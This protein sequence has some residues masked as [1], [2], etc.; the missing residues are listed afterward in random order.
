MKTPRERLALITSGTSNKKTTS[1]RTPLPLT[2][3]KGSFLA[4][5][6]SV[7][8]M[9]MYIRYFFF[10]IA[11]FITVGLYS[12]DVEPTEDPVNEVEN[13]VFADDAVKT[14]CVAN[15]DGDGDGELSMDEAAAVTELGSVFRENK[16]IVSFEELQYFTGL[17][18]IDNYAFYKSSI[19]IVVF[20]ET[21]TEI[22]EYAFSASN[23]RGELHVPGTVKEIHNYAFYSCRQLTAIILEE[24]V[25]TVGWHSFSGPIHTLLLPTTLSFMKSMAVDPYVNADPSSGLFLPDGDLWVFSYAET[26][27][28]I[29]EFAYYY[30]FG[31]C[32]LVV[33]YGTIDVYKAEKG[34]S[35][36]SSYYEIGDVNANGKIDYHDVEFLR[37]YLDGEDVTLKNYYLGDVNT[38][39]VVNEDDLPVLEELVFAIFSTI[40]G[41]ETVDEDTEDAS[42][43]YTLDGRLVARDKSALSSLPNGIYIH[44]GRKIVVRN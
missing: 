30:M 39:G 43:V 23:I 10:T 44:Q 25:E 4:S 37:Q 8:A 38:D 15:W 9:M 16:N 27:A 19:Q 21:V 32:Q 35:H 1:I 11:L 42:A 20:P 36:F 17:T 2:W 31:E 7:L 41:I 24:G 5:E 22:G 34:W 29:N 33:P 6:S 12:Q 26:P 3:R 13:I 28:P 18:A 14:L 40:T